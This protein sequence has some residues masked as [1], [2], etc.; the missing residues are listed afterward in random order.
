M[1]F[2]SQSLLHKLGLQEEPRH[3]SFATIRVEELHLFLLFVVCPL[4]FRNSIKAEGSF[5]FLPR[6][7]ATGGCTTISDKISSPSTIGVSTGTST[8]SRTFLVATVGEGVPTF[9]L[10]DRLRLLAVLLSLLELRL[11]DLGRGG[12]DGAA[13]GS[14]LVGGAVCFLFEPPDCGEEPNEMPNP[15]SGSGSGVL[16]VSS[17]KGA[18][19]FGGLL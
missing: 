12:G 18:F 8:D 15:I 1:T 11:V 13:K 9:V 3:S 16:N 10:A 14:G 5:L 19:L 2:N 7:G 6:L 17:N 4:V